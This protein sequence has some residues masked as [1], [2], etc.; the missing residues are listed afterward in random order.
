MSQLSGTIH[1]INPTEVV[2]DKFSKRTFILET[3]ENPQYPQFITLEFTTKKVGLLDKFRE[4]QSV[5]VEYNLRGRKYTDKKTGEEKAF[6]TI[7][8]WKISGSETGPE[9]EGNNWQGAGDSQS[10]DTEDDDLPF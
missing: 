3:A 6:N 5:D 10:A 7:E 9:P 8:A 2:S 4:G 1:K